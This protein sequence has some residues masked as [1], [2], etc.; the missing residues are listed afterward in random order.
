MSVNGVPEAYQS[1]EDFKRLQIILDRK[2]ALKYA[3][4]SSIKS[5]W[6]T[7]KVKFRRVQLKF[8]F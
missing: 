4:E 8:I 6:T 1:L 5:A 3:L 7:L 2:I